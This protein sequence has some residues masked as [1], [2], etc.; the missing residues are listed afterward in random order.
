MGVHTCEA[1]YRDGDYYGS[2]VN[3]AARL[4]S[5]AHGGQVV[6]SA[7]TSALL[8]GRS[9]ELVDLGEHR[10][11][12]LGDP[13]RV[14]QVAHPELERKFP[15]LQSVDELAGN[16]PVQRDRFVGRAALIE[17]ITGLVA[18]TAVVTLTGPGGVGKT[19]LALQLASVLQPEFSDGA[20]FVDLAPVTTAERVAAVVLETLGYTLA[21]GEDDVTGL[22]ARLRRRRMLLVVDNCEHLVASVARVVDAISTSA[23]DVRV[24]ATSRE[25]LGVPAERV[26]P[27]T[28]LATDAGGDAVELFVTRARAARPEFAVDAATTPTVVELCR[29]LDGIPL[30]IELAAARSRSI[31][32][33]KILER[34]DERFRLLTGGS[35]TAVARH[36]TLQAAVDWSEPERVVLD[37]LSVFAGSFTLDAAES[38]TSDDEIDAF[39]VLEHVSALVDKSL[40]VADPSEATYRLLETIRQ[41]AFGRLIASG[42]AAEMRARHAGYYRTLAAALAPELTGP[43][44]VAA[45][46][47]LSADIENLR[48]MVDWYHDRGQADVVADVI[49]ELGLFWFGRGHELESIARLEDNIDALGDDHRRRSRV[50][51]HLAWLKSVVGFAGVPEHAEQSAEHAALGGIPTPV[52]SFNGLGVYYMT[53]VGDTERAIEQT[54]L[55]VAAAQAEG[56]LYWAAWSKG[57]C[58]FYTALLA[59]GTDNTLR[60]ADELRRD[61]ERTGSVVLRQQWLTATAVALRPVDLDRSLALLDESVE[62][63]TR[64]NVREADSIEFFRGLMLFARR[65]YADAAT[66]LRRALVGDHDMGNRLGMLNVLSVVTGVADRTGRPE[67]AAALLAGLRAAREEYQLPGSANERHAEARIEEH[68]QRRPGHDHVAH[69]VRRLDI[70]A[71]IDLAL[72]TLDDIAADAPA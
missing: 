56:D 8:R 36:Q 70:E 23:P 21:A 28:P 35:R 51:A 27:V 43:G 42:T 66:A 61:V 14:F 47:R 7:A 65:R 6:V 13:E 57:D 68:L 33:A 64:E 41:Y 31:A 62:L 11:R 44:D 59:P 5:V 69:Q 53:F 37:R 39:D 48:L 29:R 18:D 58:L 71:T 9:V 24:V 32:P 45:M 63:A 38:V 60:L 34:L 49:M 26:V 72:D 4:M 16:L 1:E 20:W 2:E 25:G 15:A 46:E 40:V 12:D 17:Q 22:C 52:P 30:A 50:H 10:L 55:A 3:R 67:T 19:R 54:Q